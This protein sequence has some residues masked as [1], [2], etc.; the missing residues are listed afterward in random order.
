MKLHPLQSSFESGE[1]SPRMLGRT[2][3]D[4]YKHG[5]SSCLNMVVD[6]RGP[7]RS[8][9]GT[10][11]LYTDVKAN[12]AIETFQTSTDE[13]YNLY[14]TDQRLNIFETRGLIPGTFSFITPYL[15]ADIQDL[16]FVQE[17]GGL[18]LYI[19]HPN[20]PTRRLTWNPGTGLF[21][22]S[23]VTFTSKPAEWT[24]TSW[25]GV[26]TIFQGRLWLGSTANEPSTFWGSQSGSLEDFTVAATPVPSDAILAISMERFGRITW[27]EGTKN[28]VLGSTT[29]EYLV[30]ADSGLLQP[31][32]VNIERQSAYGSKRIQAVQVNERLFYV[33]SDG[34]KIRSMYF[35][36]ATNN[37]VSDDILFL[38]EHLSEAV[39]TDMRWAPNP[40]NLLWVLLEDGTM[41]SCTYERSNNIQGWH[42]H[43]TDGLF[44]DIAV[45]EVNGTSELML[46][47]Q[48]IAGSFDLEVMDVIGDTISMDAYVRDTTAGSGGSTTIT[49]LGHLEGYSVQILANGA[50]KPNEVVSSG[51]IT[52]PYEALEF[53]IGLG[54]SKYIK[55]L[56]IDIGSAEG[57]SIGKTKR[58]N[59]III[60]LL[61]SA[62]PL[63]N[64]MRPPDRNPATPMG[65]SEPPVTGDV[66]VHD[67]GYDQYAY[68]EVE[69]D[70][71]LT[72]TVVALF[73]D[74][75]QESF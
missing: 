26:G 63:I 34:R 49:G 66:S 47:T 48:R 57:S 24:G 75:V 3:T 53:Y 71:P 36:F 20:Y 17:P 38:S 58:Y 55:T 50:V 74:L 30:V 28:L 45:G 2:E 18:I 11:F 59:E 10:E 39:I 51:Q 25:P 72:L 35:E 68:V 64:G 5:L 21:S 8:R 37:W 22:L 12:V 7:V 46:V 15:D 42:R 54:Y 62:F 32:D 31:G 73:G 6:A 69:Q 70:L 44:H 13:Y 43:D 65:L 67:L 60:R 23:V 61:D 14:Y 27:M 56:P 4:Q 9:A 29:G 52:V 19:L 40:D 1:L 16:F 41:I 33:S